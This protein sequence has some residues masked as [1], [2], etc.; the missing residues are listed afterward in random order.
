MTKFRI[1][2]VGA[3]IT[4]LAAGY[5][6][7]KAGCQVHLLEKNEKVGGLAGGFKMKDWQWNLEYFYHHLFV[8][9]SA[10]RNLIKEIGLG[11][12]LFF[13]RPITAIY[14]K[15]EI[16]QFDS[17]VSVLKYP[18]LNL[19][20]KI[21]VSLTTV[22]LK[23]NNNWERLEKVTA[24]EWL[25]RYCG[26]SVFELIWRPLLESKYPQDWKK[27]SMAWFWARI[28]KRSARLGYLEGGFQVLAD[29]L[30]ERIT[31]RGGKIFF[32]REI[33][34]L[35][36][37]KNYDRILITV[38]T[39]GLFNFRLPPMS[40]VLTL[41]LILNKKFLADGTYW[42]SI[43]EPNW[44]FLAVVEHTNFVGAE[45]YGGKHL[46]YVGG[47]YP[48]NHKIFKKSR[49][50]ILSMFLPYLRRIK[51]GFNPRGEVFDSRL[52][53]DLNAQPLV[54]INYSRMIPKIKTE[55]PGV[56]MA[57]MQ[58]IYPW[59]RGINYAIE[60]GEKAADEIINS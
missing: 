35:D 40:G 45:Y 16:A 32:G 56:Y 51:P 14:Q 54:P 44:P 4:G 22:Y 24:R 13:R 36:D 19:A 7:S 53:V 2:V 10:A 47:Y 3:G 21:R 17:P 28:K 38:P 15:G 27:V 30:A 8:S 34:K 29:K 23:T 37:L 42:L 48:Q 31:D 33:R 5:R 60:W 52:A 55:I 11:D 20:E 46:L 49:R 25:T 58:M 9:D 43:N 12:R 41:I 50:E 6:L 57:N 39:N 59:D 26:N 1:A 18:H